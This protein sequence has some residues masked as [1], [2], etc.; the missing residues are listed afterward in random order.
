MKTYEI[1]RSRDPNATCKVGT[2]KSLIRTL[3]REVACVFTLNSHE[4]RES[5]RLKYA[6]CPPRKVFVVRSSL[7]MELSSITSHSGP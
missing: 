5:G 7:D 2:T 6:T 4:R 1:L 3:A